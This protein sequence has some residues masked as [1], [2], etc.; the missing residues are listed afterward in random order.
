MKASSD[1]AEPTPTK[2]SRA[3]VYPVVGP[4]VVGSG[5]EKQEKPRRYKY[6]EETSD[7]ELGYYGDTRKDDSWAESVMANGI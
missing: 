7:W 2:P 3:C 1:E 5:L 4:E 6:S